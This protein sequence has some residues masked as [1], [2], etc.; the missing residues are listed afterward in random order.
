MKMDSLPLYGRCTS[1]FDSTPY[2]SETERIDKLASGVKSIRESA[3]PTSTATVALPKD[4]ITGANATPPTVTKI[5]PPRT[6]PMIAPRILSRSDFE[7]KHH[8]P[9]L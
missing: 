7:L 6:P 8:I 9:S 2:A 5:A 3:R 1:C 4:A